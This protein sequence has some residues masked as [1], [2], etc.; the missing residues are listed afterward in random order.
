MTSQTW[1]SP[2]D[3]A[4]LAN[5]TPHSLTDGQTRW[6]VVDGIPFLRVGRDALRARALAALDT[7]DRSE[8][9]VA[10][11]ADR[12]DWER[13]AAPDDESLRRLIERIAISSLR[14]A[15]EALAYGP[16]A[17]EILHRWSD[18]AY[19]AGLALLAAHR[20]THGR[21]LEIACGAGHSLRELARLGVETIGADIV[22]SRLWLAR[23][24]IAPTADYVCFDVGHL[25]PVRANAVHLVY[26]NDAFHF[27]A[28]K[29][30]VVAEMRRVI[31]PSG[32]LLIGHA[33]TR[34]FEGAG[35][36]EALDPQMYDAL[37]DARAM[38]DDVEL[39][40]ALIDVR[41]PHA[42]P[43]TALESARVVSIVAGG[44]AGAA[45]AVSADVTV[46]PVGTHVRRNP[47]YERDGDRRYR[48]RWPSDR[49]EREYAALAT[50]PLL[51]DD[52]PPDLVMGAS[53][54][55]DR[56]VRSRAYVSLPPRW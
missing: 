4:P 35:A 8:A 11:L 47:L 15:M 16:A 7:G 10:L 2:V 27:L 52:A 25:W 36:G 24:F 37:V 12:G 30:H 20:P 3:G 31:G 41:A 40:R 14:E 49:Y 34:K 26:C 13:G 22:F 55:T 19:L 32:T 38:Y 1:H 54:H 56:L 33:H 23:Q 46:P 28:N 18:P 21:V 50:Y 29:G 42:A 39:T 48:V 5:D 6:P 17:A 53:L 43:S 45:R 44:G 51:L 9:L